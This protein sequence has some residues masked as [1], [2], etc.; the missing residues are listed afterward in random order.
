MLQRFEIKIRLPE[1][2]PIE[3]GEAEVLILGMGLVGYAEHVY[4]IFK[5]QNNKSQ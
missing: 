4:E 1:D 2:E 3:V 5:Q